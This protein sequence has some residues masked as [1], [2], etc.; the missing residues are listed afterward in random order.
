MSISTLQKN[1]TATP[2]KKVLY[3]GN[4]F[5]DYLTETH[6]SNSLEELGI[7]VVRIN[8]KHCNEEQIRAAAEGCDTVFYQRTFGMPFD[9]TKLGL[10]SV[11]YTLDLYI[12]L[13]R[14]MGMSANPFWRADFVF[15]V[16]GGHDAEF[17]RRGIHHYYLPPAVYG[18]ECVEGIPRKEFECDVAFVGTYHYLR[19]W[20]YRKQLIDFL[21]KTYGNRFKLFGDVITNEDPGH[22]I[23]VFGKDLNDVYASAKVIVCDSI[24]SPHYWSNRIYE[25]LGRGGFVIHP[26]IEGLEK[27]FTY[28]KHFV[29]YDY[30]DFDGLKRKIDYYLNHS[31]EREEIRKAGHNY[32]KTYKTFKKRAEQIIRI[33]MGEK[34]DPYE[35]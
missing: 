7:E 12:G 22:K 9:F 21:K 2:I 18:K 28:G 32:V 14:E 33:I 34:V 5:A 26:K 13:G 4:F 10:R 27:E 1:I 3:I 16:D 29:P 23:M 15:T 11:S 17:K 31:K 24:N 30:G 20:P 35:I 8:E 25:T 6:L 19:E